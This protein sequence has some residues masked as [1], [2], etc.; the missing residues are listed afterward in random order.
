MG[1]RGW[2]RVGGCKAGL[3]GRVLLR[4]RGGACAG[5]GTLCPS[6]REEQ[7]AV[8]VLGEGEGKIKGGHSPQG[9]GGRLRTADWLS[10]RS[11]CRRQQRSRAVVQVDDRNFSTLTVVLPASLLWSPGWPSLP[12]HAERSARVRPESCAEFQSTTGRSWH[13]VQPAC[14]TA[15]RGE[16]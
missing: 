14:S 11:R 3:E 4:G 8:S 12:R 7:V 5:A 6:E 15:E 2:R 1:W 13:D 9:N 16:G 10:A